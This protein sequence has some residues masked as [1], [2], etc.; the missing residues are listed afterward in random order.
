MAAV[1]V[2]EEEVWKC[3]KHPSKRR[4]SGICPVCLRERLV[5]L[6][7]ECA[8]VRPCGCCATATTSSSSSSSS[9]S[10][11]TG[12]VPIGGDPL[13]AGGG[14]TKTPSFWSS[15]FRSSQRSKRSEANGE[16]ETTPEKKVVGEIEEV[17]DADAAMRRNMMRKSRSVAVP[18][19][20]SN[21]GAAAGERPPAK[22]RGWYFPSPIKA[23]RHSKISKIVSERSPVYRG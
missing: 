5:I 18:M 21:S 17:E 12:T 7:P 22:G 6:C 20:S 19:M 8:N 3:P 16:H 10:R 11:F 23:F 2:D 14:R 1:Y 15:M 9:S 13:P 4:K